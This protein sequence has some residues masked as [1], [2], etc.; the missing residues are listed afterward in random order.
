MVERSD[1]TGIH[2]SSQTRTPRGVPACSRR[3]SESTSDTTGLPPPNHNQ[4]PASPRRVRDT[5][6]LPP[7]APLPTGLRAGPIISVQS[8]QSVRAHPSH[9]VAG[10]FT[11]PAQHA[12]LSVWSMQSSAQCSLTIAQHS[13]FIS[14]SG[15]LIGDSAAIHFDPDRYPPQAL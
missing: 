10:S 2:P 7:N 5:T 12:P 8:V 14:G 1:T 4:S 9:T 3:L 6:G 15:L 11:L 13:A